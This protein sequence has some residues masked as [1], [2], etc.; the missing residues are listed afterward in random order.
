LPL[1]FESAAEMPLYEY[2]CDGCEE[3]FELL[4]R[5]GESPAC[6]HCGDQHLTKRF[7]VPAAHVAGKANLPLAGGPGLCGRPQCMQGGCQGFD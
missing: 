3:E 4:V 7:S 2:T 1:V 5:G 6:P